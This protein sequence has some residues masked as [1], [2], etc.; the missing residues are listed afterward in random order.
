M[1][2]KIVFRLLALALPDRRLDRMLSREVEAMLAAAE[3]LGPDGMRKR[4][5]VG[6]MTGL[7]SEPID[8]SAAMIL[9]HAAISTLGVRRIIPLLQAGRDPGPPPDFETGLAP[10]PD[11]GPEQVDRLRKALHNYLAAIEPLGRLR[12]GQPTQWHMFF[13][14]LGAHGWHVLAWVHARVHRKQLEAVARK[15]RA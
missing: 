1:L 5:P 14:H 2:A 10:S 6:P 9:D 13:G 7:G 3:A 11:A 8:W 15:L 12:R 4:V